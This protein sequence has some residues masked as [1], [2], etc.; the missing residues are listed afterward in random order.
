MKNQ[1]RR[2]RKDRINSSKRKKNNIKNNPINNSNNEI[3]DENLLAFINNWDAKFEVYQE[4]ADELFLESHKKFLEKKTKKLEEEE[5]VETKGNDE[6]EKDNIKQYYLD[7]NHIL[8][9][10]EININWTI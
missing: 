1:K 2:V 3:I 7:N 9:K 5:E 8:N 6:E 4:K 10:K